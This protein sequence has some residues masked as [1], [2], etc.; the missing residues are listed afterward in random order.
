[1]RKLRDHVFILLLLSLV[2]P[3]CN[4]VNSDSMERAELAV[5]KEAYSIG[6]NIST[7]LTNQSSD[8]ISVLAR[9]CPGTLQKKIDNKWVSLDDNCADITNWSYYRIKKSETLNVQFSY[10]IITSLENDK[11]GTYR[12]GITFFAG[13]D[14]ENGI[15]ITS[16][17]FQ[18]LR[19]TQYNTLQ[20]DAPRLFIAATGLL[21]SGK[22]GWRKRAGRQPKSAWSLGY[23]RRKKVKKGSDR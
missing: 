17:S 3:G 15:F 21:I 2:V 9:P 20:R 22:T 10:E 12:A 13:N 6:E 19:V 14:Y 7:Y 18:V 4:A 16:N 8:Q 5:E 11:A 23:D 1:M